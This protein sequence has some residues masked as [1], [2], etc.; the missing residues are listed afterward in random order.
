MRS[1]T[2]VLLLVMLTTLNVCA[3]AGEKDIL[4]SAN[5][6][7]GQMGQKDKYKAVSKKIVSLMISS[8]EKWN[9]HDLE[10]ILE[11]FKTGIEQ[12]LRTEEFQQGDFS[13]A[14]NF[15]E[16]LLHAFAYTEGAPDVATFRSYLKALTVKELKDIPTVIKLLLGDVRK[17]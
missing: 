13:K 8:Y 12:S 3:D 14:K 15:L 2:T 11:M 7:L 6:I 9:S 4:Q 17:Y 10:V 1:V 5:E 16:L